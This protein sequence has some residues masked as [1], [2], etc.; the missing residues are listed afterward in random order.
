MDFDWEDFRYFM[1]VRSAGSLSAAGREL[2]VH[3]ST[4]SRRLESL[5][6]SLGVLLFR[7][8]TDG[9]TLTEVGMKLAEPGR[10]ME[11]QMTLAKELLSGDRSAVEGRVRISV[12]TTFDEFF[13]G[14][15]IPELIRR[16]PGLQPSIM[17]GSTLVD[18]IGGDADVAIRLGQIGA[19]APVPLAQQE[20]LLARHICEMSCHVYASKAYL[21][22]EKQGVDASP[23]RLHFVVPSQ[24]WM[25][26]HAWVQATIPAENQVARSTGTLSMVRSDVGAAIL[27][28][29]V[30]AGDKRLVRLTSSGL[31]DRRALWVLWPS[32]L[33]RIARVQ[34]VVDFLIEQVRKNEHIF[35]IR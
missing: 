15:E 27:P 8:A 31:I 10:L 22:R 1:A 33:R 35:D 21:K 13:L 28:D 11:R 17:A 12:T 5:E 2:G 32:D 6:E 3:A 25:P 24:Q 4:V 34:A 7:R 19:E 29:F 26:G 9:L 16:Y 14:G 18:L 20:G 30:A 23:E